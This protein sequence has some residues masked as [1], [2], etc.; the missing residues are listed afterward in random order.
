MGPTF[1][2][3]EDPQNAGFGTSNATVNLSS[4]CGQNMRMTN[5]P[6]RTLQVNSFFN[7]WI[8]ADG[9]VQ[10]A[11]NYLSYVGPEVLLSLP[12]IPVYGAVGLRYND[13]NN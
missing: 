12:Y 1:N 2:S 5:A 3:N 4:M 7:A 13:S 8:H 11:D 6:V 9:G 10:R